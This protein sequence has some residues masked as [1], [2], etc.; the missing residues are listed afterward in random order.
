MS[1]ELKLCPFCGSESDGMD[2]TS[3]GSD[4]I[5][6]GNAKCA[7]SILAMTRDH[8]NTRAPVEIP[9]A[10]RDRLVRY[11]LE[12]ETCMVN[13]RVHI[14]AQIQATEQTLRELGVTI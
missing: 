3:Y 9:S 6:C 2:E 10:T 8:W 14:A 5:G 13:A 1:E 7:A 12:I 4:M 11:T